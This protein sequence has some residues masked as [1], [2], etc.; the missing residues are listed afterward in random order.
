MTAYDFNTTSTFSTEADVFF[1]IENYVFGAQVEDLDIGMKGKSV[2]GSGMGTDFTNKRVATRDAEWKLKGHYHG[3]KGGVSWALHMLFGRKT[4]L[5]TW[6]ALSGLNVGD[7]IYAMPGTISDSGAKASMNDSGKFEGQIDA[8]GACDMG[9]IMASPLTNN[10]LTTTGLSSPDD[11]SLVLP[12]G[13]SGGAFY[14]FMLDVSG[15][16]TPTVALKLSHCT[17]SGGSYVDLISATTVDPA[18]PSTMVQYIPIPS[19]TLINPFV[20]LNWTTTGTP[21]SVQPL[22]IFAR[23]PNRQA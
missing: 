22:V 2:D 14:I 15:G 7:P 19:T 8:R 20:K 23:R 16:T 13:S 12:N 11:T 21:T 6:A 9:F 17:T 18:T 3:A 10:V 4:Q 5:R 1:G